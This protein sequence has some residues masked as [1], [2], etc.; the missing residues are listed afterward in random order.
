[1]IDDRGSIIEAVMWRSFVARLPRAPHRP[2]LCTGIQA[3]EAHEEVADCATHWRAH[4]QCGSA[5]KSKVLFGRE[6]SPR[7][8]VH[9]PDI[10]HEHENRPP[11]TFGDL[12]TELQHLQSVV[13]IVKARPAWSR[14]PTPR[15]NNNISRE[16]KI[17][18]RSRP[19]RCGALTRSPSRAARS[20]HSRGDNFDRARG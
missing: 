5:C 6:E 13:P 9:T 7:A 12:Q 20:V 15:V 2:R 18:Q 3:I 11:P 14:T 17:V 1:M 10:L 16:K 8:V 4:D 19:W